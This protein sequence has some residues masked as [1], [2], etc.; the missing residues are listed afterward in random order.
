VNSVCRAW[1]ERELED[2]C[3]RKEYYGPYVNVDIISRTGAGDV[4]QVVESLLT[5]YKALSTIPTKKKKKIAKLSSVLF[6]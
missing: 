3:L 5:K 1:E 6:I 2:K 4:A